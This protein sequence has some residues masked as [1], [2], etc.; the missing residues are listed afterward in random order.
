MKMYRYSVVYYDKYAENYI[1]DHGIT[2][3]ENVA[4]AIENIN[5]DYGEQF[6]GIKIE[7]CYIEGE[8]TA[9]F[10]EIKTALK[11]FV[12]LNPEDYE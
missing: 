9:S 1:E 6:E 8:K 5:K 3:G 10:D 11:G 2:V 7:G 4:K 12:P